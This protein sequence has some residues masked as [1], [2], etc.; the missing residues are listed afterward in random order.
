MKNII[1]I[2]YFGTWL[3]LNVASISKF[4]I[5]IYF[6][7][8]YFRSPMAFDKREKIQFVIFKPIA[9]LTGLF[10]MKII[11]LWNTVWLGLLVT[12]IMKLANFQI[13]IVGIYILFVLLGISCLIYLMFS[14]HFEDNKKKSIEI[15]KKVCNENNILKIFLSLFT[16]YFGGLFFIYLLW[17]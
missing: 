3:M 2:I 1:T 10:F 13:K 16:F 8:R 11:I 6:D 7:L 5:R 4:A 9:G 17:K 12:I 14:K 15:M